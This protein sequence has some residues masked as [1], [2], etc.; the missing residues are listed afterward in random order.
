MTAQPK[1]K[2]CDPASVL[3]VEQSRPIKLAYGCSACEYN[4]ARLQNLLSCTVGHC[5]NHCGYCCQ[6]SL[7]TEFKI[8]QG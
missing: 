3:E 8:P 4:E 2:Y 6:W 1:N 5:P 7:D